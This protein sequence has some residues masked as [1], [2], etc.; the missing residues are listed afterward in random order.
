M[1]DRTTRWPEVVP[2]SGTTTAEVASGFIGT[3]I[4]RFGFLLTSP[5]TGT[6]IHLTTVDLY[7]PTVGVVETGDK[8][9]I[10]DIGKYGAYLSGPPED[11]SSRWRT[12]CG[13]G[14]STTSWPPS[15]KHNKNP[16]SGSGQA[17]SS[18]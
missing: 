17:V 13:V 11:S 6:T 3:W 16:P 9:F 4:A 1:V 5:Q 7:H 14:P 8:T 10:I 2:L 18:R 12:G 15:C